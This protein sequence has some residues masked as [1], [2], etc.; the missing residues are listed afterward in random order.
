[1]NGVLGY[2]QSYLS[3]MEAADKKCGFAKYREQ[4][5]TFPPNGTQPPLFRNV[6]EDSDPCS[7][8]DSAYN[9]AYSKNT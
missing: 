8:W 4:Y 9:T 1:M 6:S 7:L 2:N 5:I 3:D